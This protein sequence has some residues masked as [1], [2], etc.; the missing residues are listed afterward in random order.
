MKQD[1]EEQIL[2]DLAALNQEVTHQR[3]A[4]KQLVEFSTE[5]KADID[6]LRG[7]LTWTENL[8]NILSKR[9]NHHMENFMAHKEG[10]KLE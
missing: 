9:I 1:I 8:I 7:G 2:T 3:E 6:K 4:I 5:N 10:T